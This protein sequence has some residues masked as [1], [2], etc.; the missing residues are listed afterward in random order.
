MKLILY[1]FTS[2]IPFR[3]ESIRPLQVQVLS[4]ISSI[5]HKERLAGWSVV[6]IN[7]PSPSPSPSPSPLLCSFAPLPPSQTTC[8]FQD[9][10]QIHNLQG[11]TANCQISFYSCDFFSS[12]FFFFFPI[13]S[14]IRV[15]LA[16]GRRV[17][18]K[19]QRSER[20]YHSV[21]VLFVLVFVSYSR[22]ESFVT[23]VVL[24]SIST[25][26]QTGRQSVCVCVFWERGERWLYSDVRWQRWKVLKKASW[27]AGYPQ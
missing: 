17:R 7:P 18:N 6:W 10:I 4:P 12:I 8:W 22:K 1:L 25:T 14:I 5:T 15:A 2:F 19:Q 9:W 23:S 3:T 11:Q 27:C 13:K 16:T 21:E 24:R 26:R 20:R